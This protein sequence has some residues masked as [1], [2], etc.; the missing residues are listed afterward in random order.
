MGN[1]QEETVS[2][3]L[4]GVG[5]ALVPAMYGMY[6]ILTGSAIWPSDPETGGGT[7]EVHGTAAVAVGVAFIGA[8]LLI[9]A[10]W[11][12]DEHSRYPFVAVPLKTF[13]VLAITLGI[14]A[15]IS[16]ILGIP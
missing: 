13:A 9:H 4:V 5:V 11:F 6:C 7:L 16:K 14:G 3:W 2:K 15:G 12:W 1:L 10:H 8:G